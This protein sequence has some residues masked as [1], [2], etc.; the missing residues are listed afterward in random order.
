[1]HIRQL[2][3]IIKLTKKNREASLKN[4]TSQQPIIDSTLK[5]FLSEAKKFKKE[6]SAIYLFGSRARQTARPNSDYDLFIVTGD[7]SIK[8]SLYYI[9]VDVFCKTGADISMKILTEDNFKRLKKLSVPFITNV[10]KE[11][12]KIA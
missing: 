3:N 9:A 7:K 10:L 8:D 6:I 12:K 11:G 5:M 1:M 2:I 4:L